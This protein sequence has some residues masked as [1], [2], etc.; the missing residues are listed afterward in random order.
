[1][2]VEGGGKG[3]PGNDLKV[4][5]Q[6]GLFNELRL[7]GRDN[8]VELSFRAGTGQG[9]TTKLFLAALR[10]DPH[11]V[12]VLLVDAE[13]PVD[14]NAIDHIRKTHKSFDAPKQGDLHLMVQAMEAWFVADS[15][16]VRR[17]FGSKAK[18][19]HL[20]MILDV[21]RTTVKELQAALHKAAA[22]TPARRYQKALHQ[23]SLLEAVRVENIKGRC[24]H[25][26]RFHAHLE[27]LVL[28]ETT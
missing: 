5:F 13:G 15:E 2:Y 9:Q 16:A 19:D 1:M 4:G 17:V 24:P 25:F 22:E 23:R 27:R 10:N 11:C 12:N 14:G 21:E 3:A 28:G 7:R 26:M 6:N 20:G 8:G 18:T